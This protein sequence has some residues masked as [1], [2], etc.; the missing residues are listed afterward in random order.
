MLRHF[1]PSLRRPAAGRAVAL[2]G[3]LWAGFG[4]GFL[5]VNGLLTLVEPPSW[6]QMP[7][8]TGVGP[9]RRELAWDIGLMQILL[10]AVFGLGLARPKLRATL[11]PAATLCLA[12]QA[13]LL[14]SGAFG[15]L[16]ATHGTLLGL[17][18]IGRA[19]REFIDMPF[20]RA[21]VGQS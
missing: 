13:V 6:L 4:V 14:W 19:R 12:T 21:A 11:W 9:F 18:V 1:R 17:W 5:A 16:P 3:L 15:V 7:G 10:A 20:L 8:M 2:L